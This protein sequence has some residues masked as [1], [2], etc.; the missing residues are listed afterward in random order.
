M[1]AIYSGTVFLTL[2]YPITAAPQCHSIILPSL[3]ATQS[4]AFVLPEANLLPT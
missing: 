4:L 3:H 1:E 2:L